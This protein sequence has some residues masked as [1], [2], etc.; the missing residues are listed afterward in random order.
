[1]SLDQTKATVSGPDREVN[2]LTVDQ[3]IFDEQGLIPAVIV[4]VLDGKVLM[5]A[6]MDKEALNRTIESGDVWFFSRSRQK[7]WRKGEESGNTLRAQEVAYDCDGDTLLIMCDLG[8]NH[9]ACHTGQ[10]SCF[11]RT[12]PLGKQKGAK[13]G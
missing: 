4:D 2:D 6:W 9:A 10:H 8:G 5:V 11:Y 1:M 13:R 3:L 7:Y 12:F